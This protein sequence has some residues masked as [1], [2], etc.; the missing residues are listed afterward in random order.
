MTEL[1]IRSGRSILAFWADRL[2]PNGRRLAFLALIALLLS[3]SEGLSEVVMQAMSDAYL[4]VT[5]FV[6]ATLIVFY[7]AE[8]MWKVDLGAVMARN[9]TWQPAIA[10]FMG[11]L[12][13]CGGAI[14]IVTQYTRGYASFG[15]LISVL[16]ATMGDAAFLLIAREPATALLVFAISLTAGTIT[17]MIVDSYPRPPTSWRFRSRPPM[18]SNSTPVRRTGEG[19]DTGERFNEIVANRTLVS[20]WSRYSAW[21]SW[22]FSWIRE[23][24]IDIGSLAPA[25]SRSSARWFGLHRR[26]PVRHVDVG[27]RTQ[28]GH[29]PMILCADSVPGRA[30]G[31]PDRHQGHQLRD[32]LGGRRIPESSRLPC[33]DLRRSISGPCSK[34]DRRFLCR[35]SP[36]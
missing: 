29:I 19:N 33:D 8:R 28:P 10:A 26:R 30:I 25:T 14:I 6:A 31:D 18:M 22:P 32:Q 11:A 5:V 1:A 34:T 16:V 21:F 12:P 27:D 7:S 35:R 3:M 2:A 13:G 23:L 17:G 9:L 4:Q 36:S 20:V 15:A 24:Q